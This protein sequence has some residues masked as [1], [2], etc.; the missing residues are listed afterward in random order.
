VANHSKHA[1]LAGGRGQRAV[2][3]AGDERGDEGD[4]AARAD[5]EQGSDPH[6]QP[7][8]GRAQTLRVTAAGT[9]L[10]AE[11]AVRQGEELDKRLAG[12]DPR[13]VDDLA[14]LLRRYNAGD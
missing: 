4:D 10:L 3:G 7:S 11:A 9:A 8:T 2:E 12:W 13:E 5:S 14:R 6:P 1:D